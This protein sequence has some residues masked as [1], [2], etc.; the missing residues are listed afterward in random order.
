MNRLSTIGKISAL[1]VVLLAGYFWLFSE[2]I[3]PTSS[4]EISEESPLNKYFCP[5]HP[6]IVSDKPG[7]CPICGMDLVP[8]TTHQ[9]EKSTA[10]DQERSSVQLDSRQQNLIG[11]ATTAVMQRHLS[12]EIRTS[13]RVAF[14]PDLYSA[15]EEYRLAKEIKS[16]ALLKAATTRL[17]ILGLGNEQIES[18]SKSS[19]SS[20]EL[21]LPAEKTWIY[22]EVYEFELNLLEPQQT[23]KISTA[24]IPDKIFEGKLLSISPLVNQKTRTVTIRS[25]VKDPQ[26][27]LKPNMFVDVRVQVDLGEKLAVPLDAIL[28]SGQ[29]AFTFVKE[30]SEQFAPRRIKIGHQV[31]GFYEVREGLSAGEQVV[32][33]ANFL[34]DS[35]S[36]LQRLIHDSGP[37]QA[38]QH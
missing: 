25:E 7:R 29:E 26:A 17:K 38:H 37:A 32:T 23:V 30:G 10:Q 5:M 2:S 28:F 33:S 1:L 9:H 4:R 34:L 13:G 14:D 22:A 18:M 19:S 24:S 35:E 11:I 12:Y 15:Q 3:Q 20:Q 21:L 31:E 16:E 6:A 36:R 27:Q 8:N